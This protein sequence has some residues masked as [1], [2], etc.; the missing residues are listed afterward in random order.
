MR[1]IPSHFEG[2]PVA[3]LMLD[4]DTLSVGWHNDLA[5]SL[6]EADSNANDL[7]GLKLSDFIPVAEAAGMTRAVRQVAETGKCAHRTLHVV[8]DHVR[9]RTLKA[10]A[11]RLPDARILL[12][13]TLT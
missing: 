13:A 6:A 10:S 11:Y 12:L 1:G 2:A 7:V 9:R 4:A 8:G 5:S 3:V